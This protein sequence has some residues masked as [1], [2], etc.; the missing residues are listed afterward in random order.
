M[1]TSNSSMFF[2]L[3]K[4]DL[5]SVKLE[6][7]MLLAAIFLGHL[8]F[9]YKVLMGWPE[10][11]I[12]GVS[13]TIFFIITFIIF[14]GTFTSV[15]RE[16]S[17]NTIYFVMSLPINGRMIFLSKLLAVMTQLI[18]LGGTNVLVGALLSSYFLGGNLIA[19]AFGLISQYQLLQV[20]IKI[21]LLIFFLIIQVTLVAFFSSMIGK[22]F[23][24]F[25][26]LFTFITFVL[27]NVFIG[28]INSM[29]IHTLIPLENRHMHIYNG[30]E[31]LTVIGG[32]ANQFFLLQ[33]GLMVLISTVFFFL[34]SYIYDKKV[35]L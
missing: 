29:F 7:L 19:E 24:K 4:K 20:L 33:L 34:I 22:F 14:I 13:S 6:S 35:E 16:W 2:T 1:K 12:L 28:K 8:Y 10:V 18:L 23:R 31:G 25:S 27:T 3:Y 17:N 5:L 32:V 15:S 11:T 26:Y 9:S 30:P 21:I